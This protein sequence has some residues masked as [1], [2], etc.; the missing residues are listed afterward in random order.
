MRHTQQ[1]SPCIPLSLVYLSPT[2]TRRVW[3]AQVVNISGK[4]RQ[5]ESTHASEQQHS[6]I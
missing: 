1:G 4:H 3:Q 2:R 5:H 6:L